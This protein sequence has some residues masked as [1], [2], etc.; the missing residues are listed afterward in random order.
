[1]TRNLLS[2]VFQI[3]D[4]MYPK[5]VKIETVRE[6]GDEAIAYGPFRS[7]IPRQHHETR[8]NLHNRI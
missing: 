2:L 6:G 1:M 8:T 3:F 5:V 7:E 4:A